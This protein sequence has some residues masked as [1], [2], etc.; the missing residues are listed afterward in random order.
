MTNTTKF[1]IEELYAEPE[2]FLLASENYDL[3]YPELYYLAYGSLMKW[4]SCEAHLVLVKLNSN[5]YGLGES[6]LEEFELR[7]KMVASL[8]QNWQNEL[9][10]YWQLCDEFGARY[11]I[12]L[13]DVYK[14]SLPLDDEGEHEI[15]KV[16]NLS[17]EAAKRAIKAEN[18]AAVRWLNQ[19][20]L[21]ADIWKQLNSK[22]D[23]KRVVQ[24][25]WLKELFVFD[26][27]GEDKY[28]MWKK[29]L[30]SFS[31]L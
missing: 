13:S 21:E 19:F 2:K 24:A 10:D 18:L 9:Q 31:E 29:P 26:L 28:P 8:Y 23:S 6:D 12:T 3:G 14:N 30:S 25:R 17:I 15:E 16:K 1:P 11:S 22:P 5:K 27:V 4:H 20:W 7:L